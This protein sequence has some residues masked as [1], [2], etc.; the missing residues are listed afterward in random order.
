MTTLHCGCTQSLTG[1]W[2]PC[3]FHINLH[4]RYRNRGVCPCPPC[5][6]ERRTNAPLRALAGADGAHRQAEARGL[7]R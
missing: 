6:A 2:T 7:K 4:D 5:A 1:W 3:A